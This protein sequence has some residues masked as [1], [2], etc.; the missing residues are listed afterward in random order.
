MNGFYT[1]PQ[2]LF[3]SVL[4]GSLLALCL[5]FSQQT[6]S[7]PMETDE[8]LRQAVQRSIP[9]IEKEGNAW[10]AEKKCITCHQ[11]PFMVWSLNSANL[12]GFEVDKTGLEH[13]NKWST[14]W[15]NLAK[16][17]LRKSAS[18]RTTLLAENDS[19]A[20]LLLGRPRRTKNSEDQEWVETYRSHLIESQRSGGSWEPMGQLPKQKRTFRETQE[21]ST[22]WALLGIATQESDLDAESDFAKRAIQ[23]LGQDTAGESTEWWATRLLVERALGNDET[24]NDIRDKLLEQQQTDGGWGWLCSEPSDAFGTGL[25]IYALSKDGV[26][27]GTPTI[28]N[29]ISFLTTTQ[30]D[31]G[32][33]AVNGTK[34]TDRDQHAPT[35]TYWGTCW[36]VIGLLET[37]GDH[38]EN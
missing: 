17:Q 4:T 30:G 3:A 11:V 1:T 20:Q 2:W 34:E 36:A 24:A 35:A 26:S 27:P 15:I 8:A 19:I 14:T 28:Q 10:I 6:P 7:L 18:K 37:L 38:T 9:Y 21:V 25:A 13:A 29:G 31:N 16:G 22:M 33:W 12:H 23:W 32:A 5:N